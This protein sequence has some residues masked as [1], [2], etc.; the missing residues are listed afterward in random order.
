MKKLHFVTKSYILS[1]LYYWQ[2]RRMRS[3]SFSLWK[4]L[5]YLQDGCNYFSVFSPKINADRYKSRLISGIQKTDE[6]L[7]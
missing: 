3:I 5:G 4:E 7:G 2:M 6:I 1:L